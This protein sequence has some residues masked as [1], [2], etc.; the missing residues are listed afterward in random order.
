MEAGASECL[1]WM[2]S[3]WVA[4][5]RRTKGASPRLRVAN[6]SEPPGALIEPSRGLRFFSEAERLS[7]EG[8]LGARQKLRQI[9]LDFVSLMEC[10]T[11]SANGNQMRNR[12]HVV[13]EQR[14]ALRHNQYRI[15]TR[16]HHPW[17]A[18][19]SPHP[20]PQ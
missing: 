9:C 11:G 12:V 6:V 15:A 1:T 18:Q 19:H 7:G 20:I 13:L 4:A 10:G 17:H 3:P 16:V 2:N 8:L 14:P 5:E